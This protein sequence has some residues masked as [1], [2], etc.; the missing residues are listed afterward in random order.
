MRAPYAILTPFIVVISLL[1]AYALN[2]SLFD[3]WV[4]L[5]FGVIGYLLTKMK[6]SLA[7]LVVALVLG[8]PTESSLR[9]AL[10]MGGGSPKI[11]FTRPLSAP[12]IAVAILLFLLPVFHWARTRPK[13][14][15]VKKAVTA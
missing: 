6:Y 2:N 11:L 3:V 7:P 13:R 15:S 9:Q 5:I 1:G 12:L 4:A 8:D 14:P 10:I